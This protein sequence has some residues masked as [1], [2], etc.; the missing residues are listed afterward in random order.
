MKKRLLT[1]LIVG[2]TA[3]GFAQNVGI[4]TSNFTPESGALLELRSTTSGFL[5]P[6]MSLSQLSGI[7]GPTEGLL[8]YQTNGTKGF[9]YYDGS[10]WM[11]F[12]GAG[13]ADNF[14]SHTAETNIQ[15][16][17]FWLSNDGGN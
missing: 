3:S 9:K 10:A 8:V 12:G 17:D 11:P 2:F 5:M 14:G 16:D 4:G 7:S 15:L 1:I 13:G 6:R